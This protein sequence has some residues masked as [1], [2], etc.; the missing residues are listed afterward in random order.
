M[1]TKI[2]KIMR[3][4][5]PVMLVLLLALNV[6]TLYKVYALEN[7]YDE[8]TE[9]VAQENDVS[10]G[11]YVIKATTQISDAYKS[12]DSSKLSDKDKET[13]DM[14]KSVLDGIITDG[15]TDYEKELAVY[16]WM[17]SNIGFDENSLSVIPESETGEVDNPYGVLK[18]R[19]AVCVGYATTFRLFM[20]MMNIDCMVVHDSY[21][22]HSWDLV[23][24]DGKWYHTDI[25]ADMS[26]IT[27][28]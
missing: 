21:L 2:S 9:D 17:T 11:D 28:I 5:T 12:G 19:S 24:L 25:Y 8:N 16:R 18:Y 26:I 4:V 15:M 10:I 6:F 22:S 1:K 14:A 23:K 7:G 13:L 20:Q 3:V 27:P